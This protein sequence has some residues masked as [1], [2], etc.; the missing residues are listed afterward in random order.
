[1]GV[2]RVALDQHT[3][4]RLEALALLRRELDPR[5]ILDAQEALRQAVERGLDL[6]LCEALAEPRR[7]WERRR[8][9]RAAEA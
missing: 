4:D 2:V 5:S 6:L 8:A 3:L 9:P 1:M 7:T